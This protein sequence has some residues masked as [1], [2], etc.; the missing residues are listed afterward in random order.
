MAVNQSNARIKAGKVT[1][2]RRNILFRWRGVC[3]S[4]PRL[5]VLS[6]PESSIAEHAFT[7]VSV[8]INY[9][10]SPRFLLQEDS[11]IFPFLA[12]RETLSEDLWLVELSMLSSLSGS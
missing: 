10:Y 1:E 6:V 12:L 4:D 3:L 11:F 5:E 9:E 2:K 7:K 8:H